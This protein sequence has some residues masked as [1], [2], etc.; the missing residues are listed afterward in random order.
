MIPQQMFEHLLERLGEAALRTR[1][2]RRGDLHYLEL[3]YA[4]DHLLSRLGITRDRLGPHLVACMWDAASALPLG[5]YLVVDNLSMGKPSMGGIRMLPD[6][7]PA[8]IHNLARGMTL[9]NGAADL[10]YG[11]GKSGIVADP[12]MPGEQRTRI[13]RGFAGLI[14]RYRDIYVPGPDVG[15]NDAD[16]KIIAIENGIDS[17]V[18]KPAD[19]GGN[20]ID[21]L[22]AAAG[23][24]IIAIQTLLRILPRLKVL[25]QFAGLPIPQP[26][27]LSVLIQGFGAVGAHAARIMR[28]LLP[29][30]R[31]VGISDL[32]GYL[33]DETG[34][35]VEALF[36]M[37]Q[38]RGVVSKTYYNA[39]IAARGPGHTTKFSSHGDNLLRESA[40]CLIPAAPV[41]NY[42]DL[43]P[44]KEASMTVDR[45]GR[46]SL[47]VEGANTYSPDANRKAV[48][49]RME[50][51][52]Y[53][54][55]GVMIANDYLVN[56]GG[57]IFAAQ[58]H[59]VPT[60]P[61]LLIGEEILGDPFAVDRW[62][63]EHRTEF[64]ELSAQ[65]LEAGAAYRERVIQR[66][67]IELVDL[68]AA[69][70]DLL[71]CK[72]AERI[73]LQ[74]L[75]AKESERTAKDIMEAIATSAAGDTIQHTA[76]LIIERRSH[77]VAILS[78]A[79]KLAGVV[80][81]WDITRAIAGGISGE[82][83]VESVMTRK[84]IS[85]RPNQ[86]IVEIV[87]ELQQHEISEMPVVTD[88]GQV[89]GKVGADLLSARLLLPIL[90]SQ[91]G[92]S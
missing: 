86:R 44:S 72:A 26:E 51:E 39:H 10:P 35:P 88:A 45:M 7:T 22:G 80:T 2:R 74:R 23:G 92:D 41:F 20:R 62:L 77:I 64:A 65:R 36:A 91:E 84:V 15:T 42:L 16:M 58:E 9:K 19:M 53:R 11:G 49:I 27:E 81:S 66:N 68:L 71:P 82:A 52:V 4:D 24:V 47:I 1:I 61:K 28:E 90:Q 76:A 67:M 70:A 78:P 75:S 55:R 37:W 8:D 30:A 56:S 13:V 59:I 54:R 3:S 14:R 83:P 32:D 73:S 25:P 12:S 50:Q 29:A 33:Y 63:K 17:A 46:W 85:A 87:R 43:P 6:I 40:Y 89:V 31:I 5:G 21:E 69:N 60:P 18:S 57:V 34:L 38:A 48:R 79:G